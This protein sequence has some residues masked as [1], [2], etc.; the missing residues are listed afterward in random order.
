MRGYANDVY[1]Q[2]GRQHFCQCFRAGGIGHHGILRLEL[3]TLRRQPGYLRVP[4]QRKNT[5]FFRMARHH[6]KRVH[7]YAAG[8]AQNG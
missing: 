6:I 4:G 5:E 8:A 1:F 2:V 7:A 3:H